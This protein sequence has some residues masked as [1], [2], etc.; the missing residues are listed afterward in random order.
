MLRVNKSPIKLVNIYLIH[1]NCWSK[2]YLEEDLVK[3]IGL[4]PY[5]EKN[6]L[7]VTAIVSQKGYRT[8]VKLKS[9]EKIK[10]IYNI[11]N[12]KNKIIVD[13][14]RD[15][16][17]SILSVIVRN[18]GIVLNTMKFNGGEI[19]NL[20]AYEY[21]LNKLLNEIKEFAQIERVDVTDE[22][23]INDLSDREL[24]I[25][26]LAYDL[27][28]FDYPRRIK[29]E[30]LAKIIGIKQSTLIYHLRRAENKIIGYF[31]KKLINNS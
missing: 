29:A 30:E 10:N 14:A 6:I 28:Y 19:W 7:R 15:Y 25:L 1:E 23:P 27:G 31:I 16:D 3:I 24:K 5:P 9:E 22:I 2:Y 21:K 11:F 18:N 12:Y 8:I 17:N 20:L 13:L 26:S 4:I